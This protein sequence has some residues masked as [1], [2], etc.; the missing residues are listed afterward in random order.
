M[1]T[2]SATTL[3]GG[4]NR[5]GPTS[6]AVVFF[7][8][9]TVLIFVLVGITL[10][11]QATAIAN[12]LSGWILQNFKW[13]FIGLVGL[14]L[15]YCIWIAASRYGN[16]KLGD[17]DSQPEYSYATWFSML[18]SAGMG[19]GLVFWS[20]A[21][22]I[23][24]FQ[25]NPFITQGMTPEAATTA[26]RITFFHWGLHPW[27]IYCITGLSLAYFSFRRKLPLTIRSCLFPILG[28]E[29]VNGFWGKTI[30]VLAVFATVFGVATS[31]GL[32]VSQ[33]NAGLNEIFGIEVS[34]TNKIILIVVVSA[35][36]TLSVV[37]GVGRGVKWLSVFN[38]WLTIAIMAFL[39][40]WGPTRF[41]LATW[42]QSTSDYMA[43]VLPL[44]FWTDSFANSGWQSSWTVFYWAWWIA[45]APFVGMFIAR[46]SR[47]RTIRE[48]TIGVLLVPTLLGSL[49]LTL[50]GGSALYLELLHTVT[51]S[52]G[53]VVAAVGQA[54]IIEA[55]SQDVATALYATL[56]QIDGG[57]V[58]FLASLVATV[59]IA[60]YFITSADS[61]TLV[62]TTILSNGD[63]EPPTSLRVIWGV[64]IGGVAAV[65]LLGGGLSALQT[66]SITA[67]FPFSFVMI[68]MMYG[69]VKGLRQ[70]QMRYQYTHAAFTGK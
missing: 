46:I 21:E 15:F 27:A 34:L 19:I 59:L 57:T 33:M 31:L 30:D 67:S 24:H 62:V 32:G 8:T 54:G 11:D 61:G 52:A 37:S 9:L 47:G 70:E 44:S 6:K 60:T 51:N 25:S 64:L 16:I 14:F 43:N 65:L 29:G 2:D 20:I 39:L 40:A 13:Y 50:F 41:L 28:R 66:A 63:E 42:L 5:G 4:V 55:V 53:E 69:L 45:W 22:P 26:L 35:I 17:D 56:K 48:F 49:W 7:S 23:Y 36:A 3:A 58:G 10:T 38:M 68:V 1:N 18:F 12:A